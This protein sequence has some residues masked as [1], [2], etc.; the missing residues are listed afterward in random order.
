M[1][2][3]AYSDASLPIY[4]N[5]DTTVGNNGQNSQAEDILL[6]QFLLVPFFTRI[7]VDVPHH[8]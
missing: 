4:F 7:V 8:A 6:A 5:V 3:V 2:V 1:R